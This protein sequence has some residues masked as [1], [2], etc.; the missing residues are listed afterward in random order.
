MD[1]LQGHLLIAMPSLEETFFERSVIYLCEHDD[2]G[3]MG[4]IINRPIG[5]ELEDLLEQMGLNPPAELAFQINSQV[6]VGGP[7]APDRG[8]VLH[9]PQSDWIN[10]HKVSD[11]C[12]LT[13]SRD[14]LSAIGTKNSPSNY[15]VALGYAGWGKDQL[16]QEL[17]E[18]TWLTIKA[19][20]DL[21]YN[22]NPEHLWEIASKQ[23]GFDMW[24]LSNQV[25]HA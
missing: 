3:A 7:V 22:K 9:T 2:K 4:L 16:E 17:A 15:L 20:P 21:L 18:N 24:Q 6:L 19:T 25:G 1:S 10:S 5:L 14:V 23:L 12:M 13:T 11:D 8:F